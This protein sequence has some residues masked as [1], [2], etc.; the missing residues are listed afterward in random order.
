MNQINFH[1]STNDIQ[2]V[3]QKKL[4]LN[5]KMIELLSQ[6]ISILLTFLKKLFDYALLN[7]KKITSVINLHSQEIT[8]QTN[9]LHNISK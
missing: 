7:I 3:I 4:L 6:L 9:I 1:S 8:I 5:H 2:M